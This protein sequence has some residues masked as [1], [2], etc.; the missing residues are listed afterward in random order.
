VSEGRRN[1]V[2][3]ARR[4]WC[5]GSLEELVTACSGMKQM[6]L[7]DRCSEMYPRQHIHR[8]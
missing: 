2:R 7:S 1:A 3:Q 5:V 6:E 8:F 4:N